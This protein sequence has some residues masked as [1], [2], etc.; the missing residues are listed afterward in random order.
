MRALSLQDPAAPRSDRP[1]RGPMGTYNEWPALT[2]DDLVRLGRGKQV[3]NAFYRFEG[4]TR[5]GPYAQAHE[6]LG[7]DWDDP[8]R[9]ASRGAMTTHTIDRQRVHGTDHQ[10]LLWFPA[11][12]AGESGACE[13]CLA[14]RIPREVSG[15]PY[16]GKLYDVIAGPK[17]VSFQPL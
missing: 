5:E 1:D 8:V 4:V 14:A 2:L 11:G 16:P 12:L 6:I 15:L 13:A 7:R 10:F 17:G 9:V 3:L